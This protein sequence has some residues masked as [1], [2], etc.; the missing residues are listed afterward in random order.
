MRNDLRNSIL[1]KLVIE[2]D[3][4]KQSYLQPQVIPTTQTAGFDVVFHTTAPLLSFRGYVKY[5]INEKHVFE[6]LV[7]AQV[8][9][10]QLEIAKTSQ[11]LKFTFAEDNQ[12]MMTSEKVKIFNNGNAKGKFKWLFA[13]NK[14]FSVEP[15]TGIVLE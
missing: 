1:V 13:E 7:L 12:D 15:K 14:V 6:L 3:E 8:E 10:V 11:N 9:P 5:I 2:N 4:L